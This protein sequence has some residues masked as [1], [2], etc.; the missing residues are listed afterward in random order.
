MLYTVEINNVPYPS[1]RF[2]IEKKPKKRP[3]NFLDRQN[4]KNPKFVIDKISS[5]V[6]V[7]FDT[8]S[9]KAWLGYYYEVHV[10]GAPE[11][12]EQAKMKDLKKF[13]QFLEM[14]VR[15]D[16]CRQLDTSC[17]Q[18]ISKKLKFQNF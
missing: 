16:Q 15:H 9:L 1:Q 14:E 18:V 12:T 8:N 17:K 3:L 13:I 2:K 5:K 10:K 7:Q 6:S 4:D 11:K